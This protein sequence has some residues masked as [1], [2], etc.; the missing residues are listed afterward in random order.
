M[1]IIICDNDAGSV[2]LL[3]KIIADYFSSTEHTY[4][5]YIFKNTFDFINSFQKADI[6]FMNISSP[7]YD[8]IEAVRCIR[9]CN[10]LCPNVIFMAKNS[11]FAVDAFNLNAKHYLL[12]PLKQDTVYEALNRCI[13]NNSTPTDKILNVKTRFGNQSVLQKK[14][15]FIEV[16]NTLSIIYCLDEQI[17]TYTSLSKIYQKLDHNIFLHP[18]R[19]YIVNMD[20]ITS[21]NNGKI[22]L[23][24]GLEISVSRNKRTELKKHYENYRSNTIL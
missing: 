13:N 20:F 21:F 10:I 5:I 8:G 24:N 4:K 19:S 17:K 16:Y 23:K 3:N 1:T 9:N 2:E 15:L 12:K 7:D 6:L 14:I 22:I 18:H 11:D